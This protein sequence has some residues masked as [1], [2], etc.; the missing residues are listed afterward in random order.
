[1]QTSSKLLVLDDDSLIALDVAE[2]LKSRGWNSTDV[3]CSLKTAKSAVERTAYKIAVI[4]INIRNSNS[5]KLA[6]DLLTRGTRV[7]FLSGRQP[8]DVPEQ[9]KDC[10]FVEK[11]VNYDLLESTLWELS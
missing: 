5:F 7:V 11:P 2:E 10:P 1:M 3:H 9:L 8:G 4:D 6:E